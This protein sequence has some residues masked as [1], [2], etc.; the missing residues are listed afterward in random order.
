MIRPSLL[1]AMMLSTTVAH[2]GPSPELKGFWDAIYQDP[3]L[4]EDHPKCSIDSEAPAKCKALGDE[5]GRLPSEC[6]KYLSWEAADTLA[7]PSLCGNP[8]QI[9]LEHGVV[10]FDVD[11]IGPPSPSKRAD[12]P[13]HYTEH[14]KDTRHI[15]VPLSKGK[16]TMNAFFNTKRNV[17]VDVTIPIIPAIK[18]GHLHG[19]RI[20]TVYFDRLH[21]MTELNQNEGRCDADGNFNAS[22]GRNG[23]LKLELIARGHEL[24]DEMNVGC[25][26]F[27]HSPEYKEGRS[28][29][30]EIPDSSSGGSCL[31]VGASCAHSGKCCPGLFCSG[32][33]S[34]A[35]KVWNCKKAP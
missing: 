26:V 13:D 14:T 27:L 16:V 32:A 31:G 28:C 10:K 29:G 11:Y 24:E 7:C 3:P 34:S 22:T 21:V 8:S 6:L 20:Q 2:A 23:E 9:K 1:V 35:S 12:D 15:E 19:D 4:G 18:G 17:D 30:R 33:A 25:D 5:P